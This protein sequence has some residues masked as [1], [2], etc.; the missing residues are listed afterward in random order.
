VTKKKAKKKKKLP[1]GEEAEVLA[2]G[3]IRTKGKACWMGSS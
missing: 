1:E 2:D 3:D